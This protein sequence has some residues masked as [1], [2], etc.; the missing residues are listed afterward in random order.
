MGNATCTSKTR[1]ST[2]QGTTPLDEL[3]V[4]LAQNGQIL[5][6]SVEQHSINVAGDS[7]NTLSVLGNMGGVLDD[8]GGFVQKCRRLPQNTPDFGGPISKRKNQ[9]HAALPKSYQIDELRS[10]TLQSHVSFVAPHTP[11]P[12]GHVELVQ[13][14]RG[15]GSGNWVRPR[16]SEVG[17]G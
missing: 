4:G 12:W 11:N 17:V 15:L 1:S 5:F 9:G 3:R 13:K 6:I 16:V 10:Q 14:T 8:C 7:A 2:F